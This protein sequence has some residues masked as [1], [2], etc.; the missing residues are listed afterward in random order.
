MAKTY[1]SVLRD[2]TGDTERLQTDTD[3]SRRV[4]R[5]YATFFDRDRRADGVCPNRVFKADGLTSSY[6]FIAVDTF[7]KANFF[8]FFHGGDAV[9]FK[10]AV[11]FI[12]SSFISFK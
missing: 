7:C 3:R 6:D 9:F 4:R 11:D 10:N 1:L 2:R 8:T 12:N 5:F